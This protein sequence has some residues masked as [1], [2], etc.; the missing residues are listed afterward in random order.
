[1]NHPQIVNLLRSYHAPKSQQIAHSLTID[2]VS[3]VVSA[4]LAARATIDR[5]LGPQVQFTPRCES[6][7]ATNGLKDV[8][9]GNNVPIG[10]VGGM[11]GRSYS[12]L[13]KLSTHAEVNGC[14]KVIADLLYEQ[15]DH[16]AANRL[17]SSVV[18]VVVELHDNVASHASGM[19]FS[20]AQVY[21]SAAGRRIEFA[22]A[23]SGCGMLRNVKRKLPRTESDEQAIKWCLV[24]GH[25]TARGRDDWAQRL[26][27]DCL[28]SPLPPGMPSYTDENHHR[29][30]GLAIL[31]ELIRRV[32]GEMWIWS[33]DSEVSLDQEGRMSYRI[34]DDIRWQ[35]VATEFELDIDRVQAALGESHVEEWLERLA[36]RLGL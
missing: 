36:G 26:P 9:S 8:L 6:Y 29:G 33:G 21:S 4:V 14:N 12:R 31:T 22:V 32:G 30:E 3:P 25:T 24:R 17:A 10:N 13:T 11:H 35:G 34:A 20:A 18:S 2:F 23:D 15:F 7:A 1:M 5:R 19:G 16:S 27:E 28:F